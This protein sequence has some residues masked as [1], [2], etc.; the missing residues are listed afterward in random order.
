MSALACHAIN[1]PNDPARG[2]ARRPPLAVCRSHA[3]DAPN[4]QA[5]N[6]SILAMPSASARQ[7]ARASTGACAAPSVCKHL[8]QLLASRPAKATQYTFTIEKVRASDS[9]SFSLVQ[10]NSYLPTVPQKRH[11]RVL[12][13]T[14]RSY[15]DRFCHMLSR[16]RR[17]VRRGV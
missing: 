15:I 4:L 8:I 10:E 16:P 3:T 7:A 17:I 13:P 12:I 1:R 6:R 2:T 14:S 9:T 5:G 11:L